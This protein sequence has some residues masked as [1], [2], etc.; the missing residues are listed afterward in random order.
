MTSAPIKSGFEYLGSSTCVEIGGIHFHGIAFSPPRNHISKKQFGCFWIRQRSLN[1]APNS[2]QRIV[3]RYASSARTSLETSQC[4]KERR[5][6]MGLLDHNQTCIS[7]WGGK[8]FLGPRLKG[9]GHQSAGGRCKRV[10]CPSSGKLGQAPGRPLRP[11]YHRSPT[12]L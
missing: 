7:D 3:Q 9:S 10:I 6:R 4:M 11:H 8:V 5:E 12:N 1:Y 2:G